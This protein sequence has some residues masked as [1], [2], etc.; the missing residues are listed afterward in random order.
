MA[1]DRVHLGHRRKRTAQKANCILGCIKRNMANSSRE[2]ISPFYS[3]LVRHH[4]EYCVQMWSPQHRRDMDLLEQ[5]QRRATKM[6]HGIM[7]RW[8]SSAWRREA[9]R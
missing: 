8:G 9:F 5:V 6:S 7:E 4:L 3:A 2:V 1:A